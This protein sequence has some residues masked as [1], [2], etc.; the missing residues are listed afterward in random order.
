MFPM[1]ANSK[2][3]SAGLPE[4]DGER[5]SANASP[6]HEHLAVG[7]PAL[8]W[9]RTRCRFQIENQGCACWNESRQG[10]VRF[11]TASFCT[12]E[13]T[14]KNFGTIVTLALALGM[15]M[16]ATLYA[17]ESMKGEITKVDETSGTISIKQTSAGTVGAGS[18]AGE[19]RDFKV[20]DPL[21]LNAMKP[22]DKVVY[23]VDTS[24]GSPVITKM[25][26]DKE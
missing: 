1:S 9:S 12:W 21:L 20:K 26:A 14:M 2:I 4:F 11:S 15:A 13:T 8:A 7:V 23:S 10:D 16:P 5:E 24:G 6:L 3:P 18:E 19:T 25:Q 17:Q 22:G